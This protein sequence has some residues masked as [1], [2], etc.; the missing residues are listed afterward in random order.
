MAASYYCEGGFLGLGGGGGVKVVGVGTGTA[1]G[2][3]IGVV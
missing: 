2:A 3:T 1:G